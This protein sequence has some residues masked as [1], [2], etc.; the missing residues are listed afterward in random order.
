MMKIE[1][2]YFD[3]YPSYKTALGNL[4]AVLASEK[5]EAELELIKV[6]SPEKA[7]M[8]KFF[9]SPSIRVNGADFE[10]K[11]GAYSYSCR[12]FHIDGQSSR[13]PTQKYI[14][15]RLFSNE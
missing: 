11:T 12:I 9:G 3:G 8:L 1:F 13:V 5:I 7:E 2:L 10:G 15:E 14:R 6:D 4:K